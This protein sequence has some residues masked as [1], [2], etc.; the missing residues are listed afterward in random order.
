MYSH[1]CRWCDI[2]KKSLFRN[3][4]DCIRW[5][6][7]DAYFAKC[8]LHSRIF[9]QFFAKDEW[10]GHWMKQNRMLIAYCVRSLITI[11]QSRLLGYW[12]YCL[13]HNRPNGHGWMDGWNG[14]NAYQSP[15]GSIAHLFIASHTTNI[16][17]N[18]NFNFILCH[19]PCVFVASKIPFLS[20]D[21]TDGVTNG[22]CV[23]VDRKTCLWQNNLKWRFCRN[24]FAF[25]EC[26]SVNRAITVD[27][28]C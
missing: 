12:Q 9:E 27:F 15:Q 11:H 7:Y 14:W 22:L 23:C 10:A 8:P 6:A 16:I 2:G 20:D 13:M 28:K 17:F 24:L 18:F 5:S 25:L 1:F 19:F 21:H 4:P 26:L 3:H